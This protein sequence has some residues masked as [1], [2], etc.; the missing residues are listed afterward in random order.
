M[1]GFKALLRDV[2]SIKSAQFDKIKKN[3]SGKSKVLD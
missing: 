1:K 3:V 2:P